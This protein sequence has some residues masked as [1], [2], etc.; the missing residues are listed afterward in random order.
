[1]G[2]TCSDITM[3][4]NEEESD[5]KCGNLV[6]YVLNINANKNGLENHILF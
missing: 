4:S 5:E 1:M 2:R 3:Q 6:Q